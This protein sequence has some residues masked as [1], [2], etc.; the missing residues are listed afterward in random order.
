MDLGVAE[1]DHVLGDGLQTALAVV[2]WNQGSVISSDFQ[3]LRHPIMCRRHLATCG[4]FIGVFEAL[5]F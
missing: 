2:L 3:P 4:G 1:F 5:Q